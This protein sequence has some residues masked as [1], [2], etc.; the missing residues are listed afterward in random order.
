MLYCRWRR[1]G[2]CD[3]DS[4]MMKMLD[5]KTEINESNMHMYICP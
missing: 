5:M 4:K 1:V 2:K 3:G